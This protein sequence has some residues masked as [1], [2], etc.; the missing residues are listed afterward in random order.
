MLKLLILYVAIQVIINFGSNKKN[1]KCINISSQILE[2]TP[3]IKVNSYFY[4]LKKNHFFFCQHVSEVC[5]I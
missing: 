4:I 2:Y 5:N 1:I 3:G